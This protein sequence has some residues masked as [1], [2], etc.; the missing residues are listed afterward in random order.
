MSNNASDS[1]NLYNLITD[2]TDSNDIT[3]QVINSLFDN[4][5]KDD[6]SK[7]HDVN[8]FN[9]ILSANSNS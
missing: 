8:S 9:T 3:L 4:L 7:Y 1:N 5:D 6:I 2:S